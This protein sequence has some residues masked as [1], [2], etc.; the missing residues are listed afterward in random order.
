MHQWTC[1]RAC[2]HVRA[3]APAVCTR[4][5]AKHCSGGIH[6]HKHTFLLRTSDFL[7][8][9][10][11]K[12]D[13]P[14]STNRLEAAARLQRRMPFSMSS[15]VDVSMQVHACVHVWM[16]VCLLAYVCGCACMYMR[17]CE[18]MCVCVFAIEL[19]VCDEHERCLS[20][21]K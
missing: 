15:A 11:A 2:V 9:P 19:L 1:Q 6:A 13:S 3:C 18:C 12:P 17:T 10:E 21:S 5:S 4:C 20:R 16:C 7:N 14:T 8:W